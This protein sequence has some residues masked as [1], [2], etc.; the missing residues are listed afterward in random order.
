[1]TGPLVDAAVRSVALVRLRVGLGDLLCSLPAL[2]RL[3]AARAD[4]RI[5]LITW[6]QMAP[7]VA[8][9]GHCVDELLPF[10][11][12]EGI[13]ERPPD[14]EGWAPFVT[15]AR[16]REFDLAL[17]VYGDRPAANRVTAALGARLFGGFA[18]TG[19]TPPPAGARLHLRYPGRLHQAERPRRVLEPL[20][21]PPAPPPT[22]YFPV[23]AADE[24]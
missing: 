20:G 19:W 21:P 1:M 2:R 9:M 22:L 23:T 17:Q 5:S 18:P 8:R 3:R 6:A 7:V 4:L 16:A 15:A 24:A 14:P 11:G 12:I 13:P 10:P